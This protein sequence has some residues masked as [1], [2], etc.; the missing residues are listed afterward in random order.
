V[1]Q[2][3]LRNRINVKAYNLSLI[4]SHAW[5]QVV[6]IDLFESHPEWFAEIN[7]R[8]V[9]PSGDR[10]KL[11]SSNPDL[12][13][14]YA[15][16]LIEYFEDHP[17]QRSYSL[18]PTDSGGYCEC[19]A[20]RALDEPSPEGHPLMTRRILTFYNEV[21]KRVSPSCP[22]KMLCGYIYSAY[23]YPP[24]DQSIELDPSLFLVIAPS[25][26]YGYTHFRP[27][28]RADWHKIMSHWSGFTTNISYYDLTLMP[29]QMGAPCALGRDIFKSVFPGLK[30]YG[31][32]GVYMYGNSAWGHGAA[33]NWLMA[34]M[35]WDADRDVDLTADEFFRLCYGKA[36]P[37][38]KDLYAVLDVEVA[39]YYRA[40]SAARYSLNSDILKAVY[41]DNMDAIET[42]YRKALIAANGTNELDRVEM[43]GDNI[44]ILYQS[45]KG[46]GFIPEGKDSVF[47]VSDETIAA[48]RKN[49]E[50][51]SVLSEEK[52]ASDL[53]KNLTNLSIEQ[54]HSAV[55]NSESVRPFQLRGAQHMVI[56]ATNDDLV[57]I[58]I[59]NVISRGEMLQYSLLDSVGKEIHSGL[60]SHETSFSF[61]SRSGQYY[62]L[63]LSARAASYTVR[64]Q[65]A[66]SVVST[67]MRD[68]LHFLGKC[69]P[70]YFHVADDVEAFTLDLRSGFPG[71]TTQAELFNPDGQLVSSFTTVDKPVDTQ[72]VKT[73]GSD[74]G[75][76]K[77]VISEA[78]QGALDDV[79]L[80]F[81]KQLSGF[82][83]IDS[84]AFLIVQ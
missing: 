33:Y 27:E 59:T 60:T 21:A 64:I 83:T 49:R 26:N 66:P 67:Q 74:A 81:D 17:D 65:N 25:I 45:M 54:V 51:T 72:S 80:I 55:T 61:P 13:E 37:A 1:K 79:Y 78:P 29:Q 32:Q 84:T 44:K 23:L 43:L 5:H 3:E 77:L 6:P 8:R 38:I 63:L 56:Q 42:H 31:V 53:L 46:L 18:S 76:W 48:I 35:C 58:D 71:E 75:F 40:H 14:H 2:W 10:Y 82:V 28:I 34:K 57:S 24:A 68:G 20:C 73:L 41:V 4:H 39:E 7:G 11:C 47:D 62:H 22:G 36:G 70:I 16:W 9:K 69:T 30:K 15:Q 19:E 52:K 12:V 50:G